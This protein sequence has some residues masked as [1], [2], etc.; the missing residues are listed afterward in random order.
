[1][2]IIVMKQVLMNDTMKC[3]QDTDISEVLAYASKLRPKNGKPDNFLTRDEWNKLT[4]SQ[5]EELIAKRLAEQ[6]A[7]E[8]SSRKP[9]LQHRHQVNIRCF[10]LEFTTVLEVQL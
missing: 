7:D 10:S 1:M 5:K 2:T 8:E 3:L 4:T 6:K 9:P